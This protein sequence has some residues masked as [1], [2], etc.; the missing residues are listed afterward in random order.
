MYKMF[1][2]KI[3]CTCDGEIRMPFNA[4]PS[5]IVTEIAQ[6]QIEDY[7]DDYEFDPCINAFYIPV[8]LFFDGKWKEYSIHI[9]ADRK[10]TYLAE[11]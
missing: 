8:E 11:V 10:V 2:Y 3:D 9:N 4:Q 7:P 5:Q 1:K 6:N